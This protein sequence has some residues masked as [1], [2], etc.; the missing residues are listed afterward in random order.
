MVREKNVSLDQENSLYG[1]SLAGR[2][3]AHEGFESRGK[4]AAALEKRQT[5]TK[6]EKRFAERCDVNQSS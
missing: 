6:S 1:R 4:R 3:N 2:E 5:R